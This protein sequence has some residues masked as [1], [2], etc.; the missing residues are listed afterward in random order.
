MQNQRKKGSHY[1]K[2]KGGLKW[3]MCVITVAY[4]GTEGRIGST[5]MHSR[6]LTLCLAKKF[7]REDQR[8]H[9]L[10]EIVKDISLETLWRCWRTYHCALLVSL[11][12][13]KV[14]LVIP[15]HLRLSPKILVKNG[16]KQ[17]LM[18]DHFLCPCVN[19]SNV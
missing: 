17:V 2:I 19:T 1:P 7:Q 16:W 11:R 6:R 9:N 10:R 12:D 18:H 14:M 8:E 5:F 3:S 13:L 15:H 4:K